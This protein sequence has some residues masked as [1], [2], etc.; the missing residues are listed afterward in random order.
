MPHGPGVVNI[1]Y[2]YIYIIF[3]GKNIIFFALRAIK[4]FIKK[5]K[6]EDRT[7]RSHAKLSLKKNKI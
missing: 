1:Y 2:I 4:V 7:Q 3:I 5:K 6:N